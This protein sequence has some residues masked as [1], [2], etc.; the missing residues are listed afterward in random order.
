MKIRS[1]DSD[2]PILEKRLV[3]DEGAAP[4]RSHFSRWLVVLLRPIHALLVRLYFRVESANLDGIPAHGPVL[5]AVTHRSRWDPVVLYCATRR[6]LRFPASHDEFVG[7]QG[8]FMRRLGSFPIDTRRPAPGALSL[9]RDLILAG[10]AVV[11]FPEGTIF[12]Y[13]PHQVHPIKPGAAWLALL[14]QEHRIDGPVPL[15]P[16]RIVYSDRYPRFRTRV[17]ICV[18]EPIE[19]RPYLDLPRRVAIRRL[20]GDLERGLGDV[21]NDSLAEMSPPRK[22]ADAPPRGPAQR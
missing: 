14:C 2:E 17:Q 8:W 10:E 13:P 18:R 9:C 21:V 22:S 3:T 7:A 4:V 16:I 20:T 6:L 1:H 11:L 19:L 12:Y 15:I 5:L